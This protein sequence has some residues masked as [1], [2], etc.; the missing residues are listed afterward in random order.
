MIRIKGLLA[1]DTYKATRSTGRTLFFALMFIPLI[2]LLVEG[3][4]RFVSI[5]AWLMIPTIDRELNYSEIDI[6]LS[7][8]FELEQEEKVNCF[9]LGSSMSDFGIDPHILNQKP[10]IS[11]IG[12]PLCFNL[13]LKAMKPELTAHIASFLVQNSN[14]SIL[15]LGISPLD[16]T[17]GQDMIRKFVHSPWLRYQDGQY[18]LEGWMVENLYTYRYWLSF[19]KY[20]DPAYRTDL[21]NQ[22]VGI[23]SFGSQTIED[24]GR[25]YTVL[26]EMEFADFDLKENDL[27]GLERI[28]S[29]NSP[30]MK[31]IAV[32]MPIHPDYLSRYTCGGETGYEEHLIQPIQRI[33]DAEEIPFIRSQKQIRDIV[34]TEGWKD[35]LHLNHSGK[36]KFSHWLAGELTDL[37]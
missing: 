8:L 1:Y 32:E 19:L 2:A 18:S 7:R 14:P 22:L 31:I 5:P 34:P 6:K 28:S 33:L 15:I 10:V 30:E 4:L 27:V 37:P 21:K 11:G 20:R 16:F 25:T 29:L 12:E 17:G 24:T 35:Y 23:D 9:I 13:A 26:P 36:D 3:I